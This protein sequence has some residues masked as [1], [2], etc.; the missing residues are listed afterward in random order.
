[1]VLEASEKRELAPL[2]ERKIAELEAANAVT[3]VSNVRRLTSPIGNDYRIKIGD[4]RLGR[5][6]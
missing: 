2:I 1:M 5:D 6:P 4:Y 3:E